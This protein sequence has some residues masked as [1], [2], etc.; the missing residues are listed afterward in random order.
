MRFALPFLLALGGTA[1]LR[2]GARV[3]APQMRALDRRAALATAAAAALAPPLC[4]SAA[5]D[6][7]GAKAAMLSMI[8]ADEDLGPTMLRLAWH[9]R[10]FP[11]STRPPRLKATPRDASLCGRA[12]PRFAR[13][14]TTAAW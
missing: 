7:A 13:E 14:V 10:F 2:A 9:S 12:A 1:A 5:P 11:Y 8:S 4:A 3:P 6:Y